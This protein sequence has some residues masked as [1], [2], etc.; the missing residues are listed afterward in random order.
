MKI[1]CTIVTVAL[2][3]GLAAPGMAQTPSPA[4]ALS[5]SGK[6]LIY[7]GAGVFAAGMGTALFG[8]VRSKN[9][10]FSTFG[11]STSRNVKLGSAGIVTA[12]AGGALMFLGHRAGRY[13]P[14][15][16]TV[17]AGGLS[18]SKVVSW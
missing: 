12:F 5:H 4:P 17:N 10:E 9:G 15:A 16:V 3:F 14:S 18:V 7:T 2:V 11:E 1:I 13:A 6:T 8:F